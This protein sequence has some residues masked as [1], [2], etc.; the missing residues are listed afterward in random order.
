MSLASLSFDA[1]ETS[2]T[3]WGDLHPESPRWPTSERAVL[4]C[5]LG[6]AEWQW[7]D[8]EPQMN[9]FFNLLACLDGV[10]TER[11]HGKT[12][13]K[14]G[15]NLR[16]QD[17]LVVAT[18]NGETDE[19]GNSGADVLVALALDFIVA[20]RRF[21]I[22]DEA[23]PELHLGIAYGEFIHGIP[24]LYGWTRGRGA[25]GVPPYLVA[26]P[27][28]AAAKVL[29]SAAE[30]NGLRISEEVK[31]SLR[32]DHLSRICPADCVKVQGGSDM[33]SYRL[34]KEDELLEMKAAAN[35]VTAGETQD[36]A[37]T[38]LDS[39]DWLLRF[40]NP[41]VEQQFWAWW[42]HSKAEMADTTFR[43][44]LIVVAFITT[45]LLMKHSVPVPGASPSG[46]PPKVASTIPLVHDFFLTMVLILGGFA[47]RVYNSY[48][49]PIA[50]SVR[51][52]R[53]LQIIL[54]QKY[55]MQGTISMSP[56][57][58][59]N[60]FQSW[61]LQLGRVTLVGPLIYIAIFQLRLLD[62]HMIGDGLSVFALSIDFTRI[63]TLKW[64]IDFCR[65]AFI[66]LQVGIGTIGP[67]MYL[68]FTERAL[69]RKF[70]LGYMDKLRSLENAK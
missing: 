7:W 22:P 37:G 61:L 9:I 47:P 16:N 18:H 57:D 53:T 10:L 34:S 41:A 39:Q 17:I 48:R 1:D 31:D 33:R 35:A 65:P 70:K 25:S 69:R 28:V 42:K 68:W 66:V 3:S 29:A 51:L 20:A 58:F 38:H 55:P 45:T 50:F 60:D 4:V 64:P 19:D 59:R 2:S 14:L 44:A 27:A 56:L 63:C 15:G 32:P 23:S 26:G 12:V 67:S 11:G 24:N 40:H 62:W 43:W 6:Q 52:L 8:D 5:R 46:L 21:Q 54:L 36:T 30:A 49:Q 13:E